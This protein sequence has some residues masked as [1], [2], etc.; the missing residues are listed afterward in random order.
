MIG[1]GWAARALA[2]GLDVVAW[3]PASKGEQR[4]REAV[5]N[6]WPALERVGL[7]K[8]ASQQRLSFARDLP[9]A[10]ADGSGAVPGV[11]TIGP[12][13][14]LNV[15][16]ERGEP[17]VVS[18]RPPSAVTAPLASCGERPARSALEPV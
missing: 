2:C 12:K 8:G 3:D 13:P 5:A 14:E 7:A 11:V 10:V 17:V 9:G 16:E 18:P 6:A 1:S 4:L 15:V